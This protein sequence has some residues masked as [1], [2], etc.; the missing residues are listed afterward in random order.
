MN[1]KRLKNRI[2]DLC[3]RCW[4]GGLRSQQSDA[5]LSSTT[6]AG[7]YSTQ[8]GRTPRDMVPPERTAHRSASSLIKRL[9]LRTFSTYSLVRICWA[10]SFT[11]PALLP[12]CTKPCSK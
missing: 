4:R 8:S 12:P 7:A 6:G 1:E 10:R 9:S 11:T 2:M 3:G 5:D